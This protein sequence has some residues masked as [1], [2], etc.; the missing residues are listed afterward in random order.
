MRAPQIGTRRK[1][2]SRVAPIMATPRKSKAAEAPRMINWQVRTKQDIWQIGS[3]PWFWNGEPASRPEYIVLVM[4]KKLGWNPAFQVR[5][6][7]GRRLPSGQVLDIILDEVA[8][9]VY[10]SVKGYYHRSAQ[11]AYEDRV[12]ELLALGAYPRAKVIEIFEWQL[13]QP[14]WLEDTLVRE[15]GS[16]A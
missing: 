9:P 11:A 16:R 1:K 5:V 12:K 2:D 4:L 3:G 15:V 8:P 10:I 6:F 13:D 14:N 7:G